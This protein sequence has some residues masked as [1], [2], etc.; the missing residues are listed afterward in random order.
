MAQIA[1]GK[2]ITCRPDFT[3]AAA[4]AAPPSPHASA[5]SSPRSDRACACSNHVDP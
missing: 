3:T 4:A 1:G 2:K 5:A